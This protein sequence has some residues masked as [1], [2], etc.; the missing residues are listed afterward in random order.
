MG[1]KV[2]VYRQMLLLTTEKHRISIVNNVLVLEFE[3]RTH[4]D[5]HVKFT[6]SYY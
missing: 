4:N 3:S 6:Y 2:V 1:M 5:T